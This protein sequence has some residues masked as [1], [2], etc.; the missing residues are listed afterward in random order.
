LNAQP[1]ALNQVDA[2]GLFGNLPNNFYS[3]V[4]RSRFKIEIRFVKFLFPGTNFNFFVPGN[5]FET[6]SRNIKKK[7]LILCSQ[8][9]I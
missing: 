7:K 8:E 3:F 5:R 4:P 2:Q 1:T 6:E 9:Q